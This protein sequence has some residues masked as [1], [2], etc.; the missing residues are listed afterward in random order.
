MFQLAL[1]GL[2]MSALTHQ[3]Y[4]LLC[5]SLQSKVYRCL[6]H[7]INI[8]RF[9]Y[10]WHNSSILH[11]AMFQPAIKGLQMSGITVVSITDTTPL[12]HNGQRPK[13]QR[14]L[15][16]ENFVVMCD[17]ECS[18]QVILVLKYGCWHAR[19]ILFW[20]CGGEVSHSHE[21]GIFVFWMF[22]CVVPAAEVFPCC[23]C[24]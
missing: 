7:L 24:G 1:K 15:W 18:D 12:P 14:R 6:A 3:Y 17:C 23:L 8:Q 13:K 22:M 11:L 20:L 2:Q 16:M 4:T 10:V 5:F 21:N 9:T 19:F